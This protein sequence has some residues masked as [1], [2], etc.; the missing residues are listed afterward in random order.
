MTDKPTVVFMVPSEH[1]DVYAAVMNQLT[2]RVQK[3][4]KWEPGTIELV[5]LIAATA[6]HG[7]EGIYFLDEMG[8]STRSLTLLVLWGETAASVDFEGKVPEECGVGA[9]ILPET[10]V[11]LPT[12]RMPSLDGDWWIDPLHQ[13]FAATT[14]ASLVQNGRTELEG[15]E[16]FVFIASPSTWN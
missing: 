13:A 3:D 4:L 12:V 15:S 10:G 9:V 7:T 14:Y 16:P 2:V 6:E 1:P 5:G 8:I 11:V